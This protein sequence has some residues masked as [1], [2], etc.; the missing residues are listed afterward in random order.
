MSRE[1]KKRLRRRIKARRSKAFEAKEEKQRSMAHKS[2]SKAE[3]MQNLK[4]GNVTIID[5]RVIRETSVVNL[6]QIR[7]L[8]KSMS[9][10][11]NLHVFSY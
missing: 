8:P 5:K 4:K 6:R 7:L 3:I 11:Y 2:G 1:D 9:S 10:D